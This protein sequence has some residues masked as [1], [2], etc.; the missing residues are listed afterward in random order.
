MSVLYDSVN[1]LTG[2]YR[3]R[4]VQHESA[5][6]FRFNTVDNAKGDG[7]VLISGKLGTK[8]IYIKGVI[9][10][11]TEALLEEHI[12]D[13]NQLMS[14][15]GK[16]LDITYAGGTRRYVCIPDGITYDRDHFNILY[17][18]FI[19]RMKVLSGVG[20]DTSVTT[21]L[22]ESG[23]VA[24]T[25][26]QTLA[27]A[28]SYPP[29]TIHKITFNTLGNAD[30]IRITNDD[31]EE[32]TEIDLDGFVNGD[33]VEIDDEEL[34]IKK[35]GITDLNYRGNFPSIKETGYT[36]FTL[37][38]SGSGSTLDANQSTSSGVRGLIYDNST[39]IPTQAQSFIAGQSGYVEKIA[40]YLDKT[41]SPGGTVRFVIRLDDNG[42]PMSGADGLVGDAQFDL[43][44]SSITTATW[45]DIPI[46]SG[47]TFLTKGQRYWLQMN[48]STLSGTDSSNFIGWYY[49]TSPSSYADGKAMTQ[50]EVTDDFVDGVSNAQTG[51][52]EGQYDMTFKIYFGDGAA[53]SSDL[54]WLVTYIKT[55]I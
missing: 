18:P 2:N 24:V 52:V 16:N 43:A 23:I 46:I 32:Y 10:G 50:E 21:A 17:V 54:A 27:F 28:G 34:T 20:K 48:P 39:Y 49:N 53:V 25:D 19:V 11:T 35:N 6:D 37:D 40:L 31:S 14:R 36:D 30:V 4:Y 44:T 22:N 47:S 8:I 51:N 9:I 42:K 12:D 5:A 29:K 38:I 13:F 45:Y 33:Y 1:I 55:Y 15:Q 41:L 26:E 7:E 3:P